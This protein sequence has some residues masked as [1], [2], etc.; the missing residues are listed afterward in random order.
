MLPLKERDQPHPVCVMCEAG[1]HE[2][3]FQ[4]SMEDDV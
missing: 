4:L 2:P 1:G 3:G